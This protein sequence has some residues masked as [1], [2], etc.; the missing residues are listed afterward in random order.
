MSDEVIKSMRET[1]EN[2]HHSSKEKHRV[3]P[4]NEQIK[5]ETVNGCTKIGNN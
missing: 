4:F 5:K 3:T 2:L 1:N